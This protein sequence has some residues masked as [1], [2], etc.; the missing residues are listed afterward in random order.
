MIRIEEKMP[1]LKISITPKSK[2]DV[3]MRLGNVAGNLFHSKDTIRKTSPISPPIIFKI[4]DGN[5]A[6]YI[7]LSRKFNGVITFEISL[8]IT[9]SKKGI[10]LIKNMK[11]FLNCL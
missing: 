3:L 10:K 1:R 4:V 7:I 11:L 5:G 6:Q 8:S 9:E 2:I